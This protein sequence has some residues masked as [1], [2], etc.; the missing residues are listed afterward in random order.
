MPERDVQSRR[1]F[2][3]RGTRG[4]WILYGIV[5][6][7][8]VSDQSSIDQEPFNQAGH[9]AALLAKIAARKRQRARVH[10]MCA[11]LTFS[12][13]QPALCHTISRRASNSSHHLDRVKTNNFQMQRIW[14]DWCG[15]RASAAKASCAPQPVA[16]PHQQNAPVVACDRDM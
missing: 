14:T 15:F 2:P 6:D 4:E 5:S 13:S 7:S 12:L 3:E 1:Q 9:I 8:R 16:L 11:L 10:L